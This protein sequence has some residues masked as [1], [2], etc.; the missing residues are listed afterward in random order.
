[1]SR[2][3]AAYFKVNDARSKEEVCER[4]E[5]EIE[6]KVEGAHDVEVVLAP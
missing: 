4:I 5:D 1:M 6:Q 3:Y 2:E